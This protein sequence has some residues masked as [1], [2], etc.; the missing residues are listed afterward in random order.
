VDDQRSEHDRADCYRH[1]EG[2]SPKSLLEEHQLGCFALEAS[3]MTGTPLL[4]GQ[5]PPLSSKP[6]L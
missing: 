1:F 3:L 4:P 5:L 6:S 2:A